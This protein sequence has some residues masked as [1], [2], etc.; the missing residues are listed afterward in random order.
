MEIQVNGETLQQLTAWRY[1]CPDN[2]GSFLIMQEMGEREVTLSECFT[3]Q[4]PEVTLK[5][6][7]KLHSV[8]DAVQWARSMPKE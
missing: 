2:G 3:G 7:N 8:A 5:Y 4:Y 1:E 6:I